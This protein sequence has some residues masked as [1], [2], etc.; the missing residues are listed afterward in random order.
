MQDRPAIQKDVQL[1]QSLTGVSRLSTTF[2]QFQPSAFPPLKEIRVRKALAL[3]LDIPRILKDQAYDSIDRPS[4]TLTHPSAEGYEPIRP[5]MQDIPTAKKLLA[6]AGY[7]DGKGFPKLT[8][9]Y[10]TTQ[11]GNPVVEA[12]VTQWRTHLGIPAEAAALSPGLLRENNQKHALPAFYT[13]WVG[14]YPHIENFVP[15]VFKSNSPSN[16][17][18]FK[19]AEVDRLIAEAEKSTDAAHSIDLYRRAERLALGEFPLIVIGYPKESW[20]WRQSSKPPKTHLG[21]DR[22]ARFLSQ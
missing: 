7:P 9:A 20:L 11:T 10:A 21:L 2:I 13:G 6:E 19:S 14:D 5:W 3:C 1:S 15:T 8:L 22:L 12:I 17:S 4:T 16:S 18:E